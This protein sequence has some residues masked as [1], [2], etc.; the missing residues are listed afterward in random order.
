MLCFKFF[1]IEITYKDLYKQKQVT[2]IFAIDVKT[3]VVSDK[4][5]MR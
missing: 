2:D 4:K 1:Q 5:N 3:V